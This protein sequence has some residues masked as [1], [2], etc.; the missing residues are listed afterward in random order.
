MFFLVTF[1]RNGYKRAINSDFIRFGYEKL[2]NSQPRCISLDYYSTVVYFQRHGSNIEIFEHNN[3]KRYILSGLYSALPFYH[4]T[5]RCLTFMHK[6]RTTEP[7]AL[8]Q[9]SSLR[10]MLSFCVIKF[11]QET[12]NQT[13]GLTKTLLRIIIEHYSRFNVF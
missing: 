7:Y 2:G 9:V 4:L 8:A 13:G 5:Y 11:S 12:R 1:I 3:V 10:Q 6:W